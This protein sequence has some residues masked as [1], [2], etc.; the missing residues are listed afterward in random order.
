MILLDDQVNQVPIL[1]FSN[2]QDLPKA[3]SAKEVEDQ[4]TTSLQPCL[5]QVE[6][7]VKFHEGSGLTNEGVFEG[8]DWLCA[9]SAPR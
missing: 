2:K 4:F 5:K 6:S 7:A 8:L 9:T 3:L 1:V